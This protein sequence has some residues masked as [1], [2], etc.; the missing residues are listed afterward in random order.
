MSKKTW[1]L[2]PFIIFL[3]G[4]VFLFKGLYSDPRSSNP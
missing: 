4:A 1:L 2:L 3:M